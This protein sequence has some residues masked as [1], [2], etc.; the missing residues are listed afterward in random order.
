[1]LAHGVCKIV[2]Q[3]LTFPE[4]QISAVFISAAHTVVP[5]R[6]SPIG[7]G[8]LETSGAFHGGKLAVMIVAVGALRAGIVGQTVHVHVDSTSVILYNIIVLAVCNS[9]NLFAFRQLQIDGMSKDAIINY[10]KNFG[11]ICYETV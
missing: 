9:V 3:I 8:D 11:G 1:M 10:Q 5:F 7:T 2:N 6:V 4:S